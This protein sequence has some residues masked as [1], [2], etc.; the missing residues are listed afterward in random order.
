MMLK[1]M[2]IVRDFLRMKDTSGKDFKRA[3]AIIAHS[4]RLILNHNDYSIISYEQA[5]NINLASLLYVLGVR[6]KNIAAKDPMHAKE[7]LCHLI[8]ND[9]SR[10]DLIMH[11]IDLVSTTCNGNFINNDD[12][13]WVYYPRFAVRLEEIGE[14]GIQRCKEYAFR[15]NKPLFLNETERVS[16]YSDLEKVATN[17]RFT[18]YVFSLED[19]PSFIDHFY[20]KLLHLGA[21]GA[22]GGCENPYLLE[23]SLER[24][25]YMVDYILNFGLTGDV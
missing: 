9:S 16:A 19:S 5:N 1:A 24:H 3:M 13:I 6:R 25:Q 10:V 8:P 18:R 4:Q 20:D 7:I 22:F 2:I 21:S 12:P 11:M 23:V 15:S 17:T 14:P